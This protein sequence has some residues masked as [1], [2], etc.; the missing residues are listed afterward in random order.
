[1]KYIGLNV[2]DR[3][4]LPPSEELESLQWNF[5]TKNIG[6]CYSHDNSLVVIVTVMLLFFGQP[7][8]ISRDAGDGYYY[9]EEDNGM[10]IWPMH[11]LMK[12]INDKQTA[13]ESEHVCVES[14]T[15]IG[16]FII[17]SI[18]GKDMRKAYE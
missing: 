8:T 16:A 5:G 11:L 14:S 4:M 9:I 3:I 15:V 13:N 6:P 17:C 7:A 12:D 18:C 1:M 2:G 10:F